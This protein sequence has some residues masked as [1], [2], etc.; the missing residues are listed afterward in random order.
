M[1]ASFTP[2]RR[3]E[4]K[5]STES[6]EE[7]PGAEALFSASERRLINMVVAYVGVALSRAIESEAEHQLLYSAAAIVE[8]MM[9]QHIADQLKQRLTASG[10]ESREYMVEASKRVAVLFSEVVDFEEFCNEVSDAVEVVRMLNTMFAAFD[11][12]LGRH[13][14][15]KVET[16]GS[17][18]MAATGLP[19]LTAQEFVEAD[20]LGMANDMVAV[21]DALYVTL[22]NGE[23]RRFQLRIGLHVGPVLAGVVGLELPR[24]CL[25]GDTVNTAARMQTTSRPGRIQVSQAFKEALEAEI[26]GSVLNNASRLYHLSDQG[27]REVKGKG[28]MH[29]FFVEPIRR[30]RSSFVEKQ[31]GAINET[32]S[33]ALRKAG[34]LSRFVHLRNNTVSGAL[35]RLSSASRFDTE[36]SPGSQRLGSSRLSF[37]A[38]DGF[39]AAGDSSPTGSGASRASR[40]ARHASMSDSFGRRATHTEGS[41]RRASMTTEGEG[42]PQTSGRRN[43]LGGSRRKSWTEAVGDLP[44]PLALLKRDNSATQLEPG[45]PSSA[46][47]F[48]PSPLGLGAVNGSKGSTSDTDAHASGGDESPDSKGSPASTRAARRQSKSSSG[49]SLFARITTRRATWSEDVPSP[50]GNGSPARVSAVVE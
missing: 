17:V 44:S 15:Y 20:L 36:G 13:S 35:S 21:M 19:F 11:A 10:V 31:T 30:R 16:V 5:T 7:L 50:V 38:G 45:S 6:V 43:S 14:V 28:L 48:K 27:E 18:Y 42:S 33:E 26:G 22:A 39:Y 24:Y 47:T 8:G 12:L 1:T 46:T 34:L 40:A 41:R 37:D 29:T 3:R 2:S 4:R 25:F 32:I 9:P 23:E 49:S